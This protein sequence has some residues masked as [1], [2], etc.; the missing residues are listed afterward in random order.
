MF[1]EKLLDEMN[2]QLNYE[3]FSAYYYT[4][5]EVYCSEKQLDGFAN[6]F[7]EQTKEELD[8]ARMFFD[9]IQR[10]NGKIVLDTID[11]PDSD[12]EDLYDVFKKGY[13]HEQFVT[14]R[15]YKLM[16][17][18]TDEREHSTISFL[19]WFVDEQVEEEETFQKIMDK[20]KLIGDNVNALLQLDAKLAQRVYTPQAE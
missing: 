4:A 18:A 14:S 3:L 9:F 17:I 7:K 2:K 8:H 12:F 13:E 1:S 20:I 5:M 16:D 15:I 11:K 10:K 6:F 19:N